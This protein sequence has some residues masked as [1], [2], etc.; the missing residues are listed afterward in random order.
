[1]GVLLSHLGRS[2]Y[3]SYDVMTGWAARQGIDFVS[4]TTH[5]QKIFNT[6]ILEG[7]SNAGKT[8]AQNVGEVTHRGMPL[9]RNIVLTKE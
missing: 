6:V 3:L 1:M 9:S 2:S 7:Q 4:F 5:V 8:L